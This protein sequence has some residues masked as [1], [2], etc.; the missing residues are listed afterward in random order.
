MELS[1]GKIDLSPVQLSNQMLVDE[2]QKDL[3]LM[4]PCDLFV[5]HIL[6]KRIP[7]NVLL[8]VVGSSCKRQRQLVNE[9]WEKLFR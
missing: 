5:E 2:R 7:V 6:L 1:D 3:L 8:R 4:I 9:Q